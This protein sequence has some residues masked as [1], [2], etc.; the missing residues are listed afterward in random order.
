MER[1]KMLSAGE[2]FMKTKL[3][4]HVLFLVLMS[5]PALARAQGTAFSY[6]GHLLENGVAAN[7][8]HDFIFSLF[9]SATAGAQIGQDVTLNN[10]LVANGEFNVI[11][12]FGADAFPGGPRWL[13]ISVRPAGGGQFTKMDARVSLLPTPYA[14][15]AA[16]AG[17]VANGVVTANQLSTGGVAPAQ[18]QF[19]SYS[20]GNLVWS[21]PAVAVGNVWSLNGVLNSYYNT[22]N[23][24]IGTSTPAPGIKLKPC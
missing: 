13:E 2:N 8:G 22:G 20:A 7:G 1:D 19:L 23:V 11:L 3:K 14:I 12:D 6:Q 18:G 4:L 9:D 21:D 17:S 24:G 15:L 16:T 5:L 10:T